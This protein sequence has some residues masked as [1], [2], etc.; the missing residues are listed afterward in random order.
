MG[1]IP[2]KSSEYMWGSY[3]TNYKYYIR[4]KAN[5]D[6]RKQQKKERKKESTTTTKKKIV[7]LI[8]ISSEHRQKYMKISKDGVVRNLKSMKGRQ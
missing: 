1:I 6:L 2:M 8:I 4:Q 3:I 5:L 7:C